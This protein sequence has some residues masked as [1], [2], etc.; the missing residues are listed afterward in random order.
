[1]FLSTFPLGAEEGFGP[2]ELYALCDVVGLHFNS[3]LA[4][5]D[6]NGSKAKCPRGPLRY[7]SPVLCFGSGLTGGV[8]LG[9]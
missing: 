6:V 4:V 2:G 5:V 9:S 7:I 1:M 3:R 8:V